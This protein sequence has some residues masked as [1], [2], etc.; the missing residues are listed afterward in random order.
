[1]GIFTYFNFRRIRS[2]EF[3]TVSISVADVVGSYVTEP[4]HINVMLQYLVMANTAMGSKLVYNRKMLQT[5]VMDK[6]RSEIKRI[7]GAVLDLMSGYER[8]EIAAQAE[9]LSIVKPFIDNY[10]RSIKGKVMKSQITQLRDLFLRYDG[11]TV[12]QASVVGLQLKPLFDGLR[13]NYTMLN[14]SA[15]DRSK[16]R[17]D[18]KKDN[19]ADKRKITEKAISNLLRA[20]ELAII[21]Q[22]TLD[23]SQMVSE[24]NGLIREE[25][26]KADSRSTR[27]DNLKE[28]GES[29]PDAA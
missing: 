17:A 10:A 19:F 24:I 29:T 22:P 23:Y 3:P 28:E 14:D 27:R 15:A 8:G 16:V 25:K 2:K 9:D 7:V 13:V 4:M 5:T 12:L 20:I 26:G 11:D 18:R 21:E 6:S 1:M